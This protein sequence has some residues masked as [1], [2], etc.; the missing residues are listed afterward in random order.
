MQEFNQYFA[1][2]N[3]TVLVRVEKSLGGFCDLSKNMHAIDQ[4][5]HQSLLINLIVPT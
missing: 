5:D 2:V 4:L 1:G 3:Y